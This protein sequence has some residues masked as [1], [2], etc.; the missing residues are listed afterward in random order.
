[1]TANRPKLDCPTEDPLLTKNDLRA[2]SRGIRNA[3]LIVT[4]AWALV[5]YWWLK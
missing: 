4:P 2:L 5:L 1:M 3:V